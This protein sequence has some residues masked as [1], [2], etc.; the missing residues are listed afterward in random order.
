MPRANTTPVQIHLPREV[1][2]ALAIAVGGLAVF[3]MGAAAVVLRAALYGEPE[4][5]ERAFRLLNWLKTTP[6]P[7]DPDPS[8][9]TR[10]R[11]RPAARGEA[12][13]LR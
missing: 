1:A 12:L 4:E 13:T 3:A 5:S 10:R 2:I 6:A 11:S 7:E 8:P 9:S